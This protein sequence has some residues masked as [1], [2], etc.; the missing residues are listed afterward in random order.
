MITNLTNLIN[1]YDVIMI[2]LSAQSVLF[3]II[4]LIRVYI[5]HEQK[6]KVKDKIKGLRLAPHASYPLPSEILAHAHN[7]GS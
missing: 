6:T 3:V 5:I 7:A 4:R 1:S 2:S